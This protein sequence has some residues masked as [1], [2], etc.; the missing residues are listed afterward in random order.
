MPNPPN[1]K[2]NM[3]VVLPL[4]LLIV[5]AA[6]I[7]VRDTKPPPQRQLE[8]PWHW[9]SEKALEEA[10]AANKPVLIDFY[11]D[12]CGPCKELDRQI[13][14]HPRFLT[15]ANDFV[16]LRSNLTDKH[17]SEVRRVGVKYQIDG[18]PTM[19]FLDRHGKERDDLRFI[20][21]ISNWDLMLE[22]T[23]FR[24]DLA[25]TGAPPPRQPPPL[26]ERSK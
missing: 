19:V 9:Y 15:A 16:L 14:H 21:G 10:K 22:E 2:L 8:H 7:A 23:L 1:K 6:V 18:F 17:K 26:A 20:G 24:M 12:W 5:V 3:A 13:F 4:M 25:K 11:A